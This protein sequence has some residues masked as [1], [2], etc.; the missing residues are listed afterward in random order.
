MRHRALVGQRDLGGERIA[1]L[2]LDRDHQVHQ[3]ERVE[4]A[5]PAEERGSLGFL[6][7]LRMRQRFVHLVNRLAHHFQDSLAF[8]HGS[9]LFVIGQLVL[10]S[11]SITYFAFPLFSLA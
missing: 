2:L 7:P 9:P 1:D 6:Q 11:L 4:P 8:D 3:P 10:R 5:I